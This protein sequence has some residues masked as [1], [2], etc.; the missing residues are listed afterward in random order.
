MNQFV[1]GVQRLL[2][3][4][5]TN[6][7][8]VEDGINGAKT[9][10]ALRDATI[11]RSPKPVVVDGDRTSVGQPGQKLLWYPLSER[12]DPMKTNGKYR[13]GYPEGLL[14]HFTEGH[15]DNEKDMVNSMNWGRS[16]GYNFMGIG[17]TGRVY[18]ASSLE[19]WGSH[20]GSSSWS[21]LGSSVSQYLVGVEIAC[22]GNVDASG[23][24]WFGKTYRKDRL[25]VVKAE[26]NRKAGTY[27][28]YTT[29]QEEALIGLC[30][31]LKSNN[32]QVFDFDLVLGHDE[33]SPG[34]KNDPG[35]SLSM[36]MPEFRALLK[37]RWVQMS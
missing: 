5:G 7:P 18:Q 8:L 37:Q 9:A 19:H 16:Q 28:K 15:C 3:L 26:A 20:A 35:G 2:N 14:V 33:V 31:W 36:T 6:P 34:R 1:K 11:A 22:A 25:R 24:S 27:V 10:A 4:L 17:P 32:P 29:E 23:K 13:K 21:T 12:L 30:L